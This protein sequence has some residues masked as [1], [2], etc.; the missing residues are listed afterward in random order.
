MIIFFNSCIK[1]YC[2]EACSYIVIFNV[3]LNMYIIMHLITIQKDFITLWGFIIMA[4]GLTKSY[5]SWNIV[6]I[7]TTCLNFFFSFN[8]VS[9]K[10]LTAQFLLCILHRFH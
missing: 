10:V 1:A 8:L 2:L 6:K 3:G 9:T 5:L 4:H 7:F